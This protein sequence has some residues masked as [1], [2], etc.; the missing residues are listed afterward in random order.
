[1]EVSASRIQFGGRDVLHAIIYDITE[2]KQAE[3]PYYPNA[4]DLALTLRSIGEGVISTDNEGII[5]MFNKAAETLTRIGHRAKFWEV[6]FKIILI[7]VNESPVSCE[8]LLKLL[9][10]R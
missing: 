8:I 2:Q 7:I 6:F 10:Y 5:T 1:V 9:A 3:N 4:N